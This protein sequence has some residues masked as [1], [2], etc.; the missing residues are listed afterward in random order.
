MTTDQT[1]P[2]LPSSRLAG[3]DGLRA[4]LVL[5][6]VVHHVFSENPTVRQL[7]LGSL[8]VWAFFTLSG[9]LLFPIL[10]SARRRIEAGVS[11]HV[12]EIARFL[13]DRALR[14]LPAYY[15]FLA[16]IGIAALLLPDF[17]DLAEVRNG[18][19]WFLLYATNIYIGDIR[20]AWIG[21]AGH[22]WSLAVEQQFYLGF[23]LLFLGIPARRWPWATLLALAA[24]VGA[25]VWTSHPDSLLFN[26]TFYLNSF[27]GFAAIAI[28][29]LFGLL[30]DRLRDPVMTHPAA[31]PVLAAATAAGHVTLTLSGLQPLAILVTPVLAGLLI[32][33]LTIAG[34]TYLLAVLDARPLRYLGRISY[35]VYLYHTAFVLMTKRALAGLGVT[36]D[37]TGF[38]AIAL[39]ATLAL[40]LAAAALSFHTLETRFLALKRRTA[41]A[42]T[43]LAPPMPAA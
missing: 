6:V 29:G 4:V 19:P 37:S 10:L 9:F 31:G 17:R 28:G 21:F 24:L 42:A 13:G 33:H 27:T 32:T 8:A 5:L 35:G 30:G 15:A 14:I 22:I 34:P 3:L 26:W 43:P 36:P 38:H 20:Q 23:P 18:F 7:D 16:A 39:I 40:T 25:A 1:T 12:R 2:R 11:T 41:P